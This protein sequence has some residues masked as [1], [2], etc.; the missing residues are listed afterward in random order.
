MI[1]PKEGSTH[2]LNRAGFT[3]TELLVV[4]AIIGI[5]AALLL[6]AL[7]HAKSAA[8]ATVCKGHL[9]QIGLALEMYVTD[10]KRYPPMQDLQLLGAGSGAKMT[11]WA[12]QLFPYHPLAWTNASWQCPTYVASGGRIRHSVIPAEGLRGS[13]PVETGYGYN[14]MGMVWINGWPKLGLGPW[15]FNTTSEQAVKVP[16]EMY[17][18]SDA[19]VF[20]YN[21]FKGLTGMP[22]LHPWIGPRGFQT[23]NFSQERPSPHSNGHNIL[24]GDGH[25]ALIK[26]KE[27]LY[28]P[29][30]AHHWNRDYQPHPELWAA[31]SDWAQ[32]N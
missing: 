3:L 23:S 9:K 31:K 4:I 5:L 30:S 26:R 21:S 28:P 11:T 13:L 19:R 1:N 29:R 12:D 27:F 17:E 20:K 10:A 14:A 16:S 7:A 24:F 15:A 22:L 18:V 25:V 6:P 32:Q 8:R 2:D